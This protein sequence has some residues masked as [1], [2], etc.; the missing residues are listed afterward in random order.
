MKNKS[1]FTLI[2]LLAVIAVLG[3]LLVFIVPKALASFDN[4]RR[5][6]FL[7]DAKTVAKAA[8][9]AILQTYY[10]NDTLKDEYDSQYDPLDIKTDLE[11][12]L[13]IEDKVITS[14]WVSN[15]KY[16]I[17]IT[18]YTSQ[19]DLKLASVEKTTVNRIPQRVYTVAYNCN[20][21]S[22]ITPNSSHHFYEYEPLTSN[23]CVYNG[24]DYTLNFLGWATTAGATS[25][26]YTNGQNVK[27]LTSTIGATVT[28]YAVWS[29]TYTYT[30]AYNCNGGTGSIA[31][32]THR[33]NYAKNLSANTCY[34]ITAGAAGNVGVFKGWSTNSG[35]TTPTY[36]NGQ[37]VTNLSATGGVTVTFY[38]VWQNLFTY[39]GSYDLISEGGTNWRVRILTGSNT[40]FTLS[41]AVTIEAFLVGG[42]G[43]GAANASWVGGGGGGGGRTTYVSSISLT[44]KAYYF[45]IGY[46][47]G[48]GTSG[49]PSSFAESG[50]FNY[51]AAGGNG[52][53]G[54]TGQAGGSGGG[55][56]G[57]NGSP[58]GGGAGGSYGANGSNNARGNAAGGAGQGSTTCEFNQGT[59]SGCNAGVTIYAGGGGGGGGMSGSVAGASGSVGAGCGGANTGCGGQGGVGGTGGT[60]SGIYGIIVIR[61]KR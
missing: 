34:K 7:T 21:G 16:E 4:A 37:S 42:G 49:G 5:E 35:A 43:G 30:V 22:G 20:G 26:T 61:N 60:Q 3:L 6:T 9:T 14:I 52:G 48:A 54:Q 18:N 8:Q 38:A 25:P 2:E 57:H 58:S 39:G 11:Y 29:P 55:A 32:T 40:A 59:T 31:S 23:N 10:N 28:L 15:G 19:K 46:G 13:T 47:G 36:T 51:T 45:T 50:G 27:D 12:R 53:S 1:G 44:A 33:Y 17:Y 24:G 56:G 41:N